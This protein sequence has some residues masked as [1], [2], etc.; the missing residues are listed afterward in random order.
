MRDL[1]R[2]L[3]ESKI[4]AV[5]H[6]ITPGNKKTGKKAKWR[7]NSP[8]WVDDEHGQPVRAW[9]MIPYIDAINQELLE[10]YQQT[11]KRL[12]KFVERQIAARE[13]TPELFHEWGLLCRCAGALEIVYQ[14]RPDAGRLRGSTDHIHEQKRY[15]AH[16]FLSDFKKMK[17]ADALEKAEEDINRR[18]NELG[19]G[20]ERD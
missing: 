2:M 16:R 12:V 14:S 1:F 10:D 7:D 3:I 15:F 4:D 8:R 18:Y 13:F 5:G 17:R 19:P 20:T 9:L 6:R 11:R